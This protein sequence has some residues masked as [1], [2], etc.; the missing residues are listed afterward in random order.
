MDVMINCHVIDFILGSICNDSKNQLTSR[1][2]HHTFLTSAMTTVRGMGGAVTVPSRY[3]LT[4][5]DVTA[6]QS[7][8]KKLTV[9]VQ[10]RNKHRAV[11]SLFFIL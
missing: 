2:K 11:Y 3:N 8:V 4:G 7:S 5:S 6:Q 1:R 10:L 9:V